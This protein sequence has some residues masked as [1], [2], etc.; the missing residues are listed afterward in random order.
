MSKQQ[1]ESLEVKVE[2]L[3]K[4]IEKLESLLSA[5]TRSAPSGENGSRTPSID[6]AVSREIILAIS[7]KAGTEPRA[8]AGGVDR[9]NR[10]G[11]A[12]TRHGASFPRN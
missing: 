5:A 1:I 9:P 8:S 12:R 10:V 7:A 3:Q 6:G 4:R 2:E 11:H